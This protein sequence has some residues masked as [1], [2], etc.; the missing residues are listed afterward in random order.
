MATEAKTKEFD[1]Q[2]I[3]LSS[4]DKDVVFQRKCQLIVLDGQSKGKKIDLAKPLLKIGKKEDNDPVVTE[5]TIS[6]Y[7]LT[8]E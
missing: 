7:H 6:R 1:T 5:G 8:I 2:V 4:D 3:S